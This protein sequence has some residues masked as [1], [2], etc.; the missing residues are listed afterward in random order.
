M[1]GEVF[2]GGAVADGIRHP[3]TRDMSLTLDLTTNPSRAC[4]SMPRG[5]WTAACPAAKES[6]EIHKMVDISYGF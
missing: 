1:P 4:W 5:F 6:A 3:Y 2:Y